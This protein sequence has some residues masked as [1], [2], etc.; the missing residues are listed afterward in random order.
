MK[1]RGKGAVYN[2][3]E[4]MAADIL[5]KW[6]KERIQHIREK[7]ELEDIGPN[8]FKNFNTKGSFSSP[9]GN[10]ILKDENMATGKV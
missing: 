10:M 1:G 6:A 2:Y 8:K 3:T 9:C 5:T 7:R 4:D